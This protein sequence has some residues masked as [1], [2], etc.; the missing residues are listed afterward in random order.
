MTHDSLT[1]LTHKTCVLTA[2]RIIAASLGPCLPFPFTSEENISVARFQPHL[3]LSLRHTVETP[4][5]TTSHKRPLFQNTKSF[6]V[7]LL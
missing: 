1:H 7:K 2:K 5:A 4:L 3:K 6:Q